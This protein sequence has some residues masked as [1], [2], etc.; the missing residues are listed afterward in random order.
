MIL[1]FIVDER[2]YDLSEHEILLSTTEYIYKTT[3]LAIQTMSKG[4]N[5]KMQQSLQKHGINNVPDQVLYYYSKTYDS[6]CRQISQTD[7]NSR[8]DEFRHKDFN[9]VK[10]VCELYYYKD[11][12]D[13]PVSA[14]IT[15][16]RKKNEVTIATIEF[17][18]EIEVQNL[19]LPEWLSKL[20]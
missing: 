5:D 13:T 6:K 19:V 2:I 15:V 14:F 12:N 20:E 8:F 1:Q 7:F 11:K 3:R 4:F 16:V 17:N 18:S 9:T 10:E